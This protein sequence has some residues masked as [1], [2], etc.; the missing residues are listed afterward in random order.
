M[1]KIRIGIVNSN[2]VKIGPY[3]KKGTEIFSYI[4][5]SNLARRYKSEVDITSFCSGDSQLPGKK[6][7][8]TH[9]SSM[10]TDYIGKLR[11]HLFESALLSKAISLQ[12]NFDIFHLNIGDGETFLPFARFTK[13]PVVI[14]MH[15]P[16]ES[17]FMS[18]YFSLF[19]DLKNI[20]FVAI[21]DIQKKFPI[22]AK[23]KRIYH[24]IDVDGK[25]TFNA[26]GGKA[27]I[28]T[29]RAMPEK[30]LDE[31]LRI[32]KKLK[33]SAKV[34]PIIK[35]EYIN[36]LYKEVLQHHDIVNQI[37]RVRLEFNTIR[38]KLILEYQNSRAFLFPLKW[39]EPFGFTV[40]ESM[41]C[42]TPVIAY[43]RG[44]M[45]ELIK[46]GVTGYLVN[47][48]DD[49]IRGDFIVKKTGFEGLCEAVQKIYALDQP[50]YE[51]M[52]L[53]TRNHAA[54]TFNINSMVDNYVSLYRDIITSTKTLKNHIK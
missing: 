3:T 2:Y 1:R 10:E 38:S 28:W 12:K 51:L 54:S 43:A 5:T 34:F 27:L 19:N 30:G 36:W 13:K 52:R 22:F 11:N 46:D 26:Q 31:V 24:G 41:A 40:V 37:A 20:H 35:S 14:T 53:M 49:D 48:S 47:P 45:Q 9:H 16:V 42:G 8:V 21:S 44:S 6:I 33:I 39:E 4:F 50:D 32:S 23:A 29:G 17:D 18:K 15:G 25:F 7:S